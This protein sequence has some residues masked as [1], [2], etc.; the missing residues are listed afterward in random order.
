MSNIALLITVAFSWFT[1]ESAAV[2]IHCRQP[3]EIGE[4]RAVKTKLCVDIA[5]IKGTGDVGTNL[6]DG[7]A[8][9]TL[10]FCGDGIVRNLQDP[11]RCVTEVGTKSREVKSFACRSRQYSR[12]KFGRLIAFKDNAGLK[13]KAREIISVKTGGYLDASDSDNLKVTDGHGRV[14]TYT[15]DY[16][17]DPQ[18]FYFR[19]RGT[20]VEHGKLK[21]KKSGDCLSFKGGWRI[22]KI[23]V[24]SRCYD[25]DNQYFL[26]YENGELVSEKSGLCLDIEGREGSGNI[27]L[28]SCEDE[29]DQM[30]VRECAM[31]SPPRGRYCPF[32]SKR[33]KK[34]LTASRPNKFRRA[35]ILADA[36]GDGRTDQ[37]F[38]WVGKGVQDRVTINE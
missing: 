27:R 23:V 28:Y 15:R 29:P 37:L 38:K 4:L 14:G 24:T 11:Q 16:R 25:V 12:W 2:E 22:R 20:L 36:C 26:F 8:D 30:W 10:V 9:Q 33:S 1:T 35:K 17:N 31:K 18:L 6:C 13:Q 21:I 19:S 7:N 3:I 32:V 5:G 34:C